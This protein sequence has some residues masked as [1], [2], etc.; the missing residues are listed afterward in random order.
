MVD[1]FLLNHSWNELNEANPTANRHKKPAQPTIRYGV[2]IISI[3]I[4][5]RSP[6]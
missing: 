4:T 6:A 5:P 2:S 1:R 3:T